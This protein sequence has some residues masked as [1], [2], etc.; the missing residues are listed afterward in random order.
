MLCQLQSEHVAPVCTSMSNVSL[1]SPVKQNPKMPCSLFVHA[2]LHHLPCFTCRHWWLSSL[3]ACIVLIHPDNVKSKPPVHQASMRSCSYIAYHT[4]IDRKDT[5]LTLRI[6]IDQSSVSASSCPQSSGMQCMRARRSTLVHS[7]QTQVQHSC[8]VSQQEPAH[9]Y[10][11]SPHE[12]R[13]LLHTQHLS[14][15]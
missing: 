14:H 1:Q 6:T 5:S 13:D 7:M 15:N 12:L 9:G 10:I 4:V 8:L 2:T 11:M 3:L